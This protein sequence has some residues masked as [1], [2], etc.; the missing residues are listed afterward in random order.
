[1]CVK[2]LSVLCLFTEPRGVDSSLQPILTFSEVG[3]VQGSAFVS[4]A[5]I[6]PGSKTSLIHTA[7]CQGRKEGV[8]ES[9]A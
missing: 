2:C 9:Q 4:S 3:P 7:A 6:P 8:K 5:H 1:M